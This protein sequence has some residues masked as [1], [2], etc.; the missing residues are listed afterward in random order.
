[1]SSNSPSPIWVEKAAATS[2]QSYPTGTDGC[3]ICPSTA[4]V[5]PK[6]PSGQVC[7]QMTRTCSTCPEF[8]CVKADG[9]SGNSINGKPI[10]AIIGGVVGGVGGLAVLTIIGF[11]FY[12]KLVYRKKNPRLSGIELG[13]ELDGYGG[14]EMKYQ[15]SEASYDRAASGARGGSG[16]VGG[17]GSGIGGGSGGAGGQTPRSHRL[18]SYESFMRPP[19]LNKRSPSSQSGLGSGARSNNGSQLFQDPSYNGLELSKRNSIATTVST[20]NASNILPI[21]YIPGVTI[22]PT[23]NNTRSI[24]SYE[25]ESLSSEQVADTSLIAQH[26]IISL[27]NMMT[28]VRAQPKLINVARIEEDEEPEDEDEFYN[29]TESIDGGSSIKSGHDQAH[30]HSN[31]FAGLPTRETTDK[32]ETLVETDAESDSYINSGLDSDSDSDVDS[33]I[34][35]I[36]RA[37]S[38]RR[39]HALSLD[40]GVENFNESDDEDRG[41]FI[42]PIIRE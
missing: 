33:D 32:L 19:R 15:D 31:P 27:G 28:A 4:P 36:Q 41:S 11:Y 1:M 13:E 39:H 18:S 5:C 14:S 8:V 24:Y 3:V 34:G 37:N 12:Y 20:S 38:K 21:A 35:E 7:N 30:M 16:S 29:E 42:I 9:G 6:C 26:L 23:K 10:G 17:A 40:D 2:T 22:R 25:V